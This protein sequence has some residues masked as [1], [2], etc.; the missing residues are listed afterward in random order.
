MTDVA[1]D[2]QAAG[3][4]EPESPRRPSVARPLA[5]LLLA[6]LLMT[7]IV[8][9][10]AVVVVTRA[11]GD[12]SVIG[13][14]LETAMPYLAAA[15]HLVLFGLLL[16]FLR[17]DGLGLKEIGWELPEGGSVKAASI[18]L[19]VGLAAGV[20]IYWI[21][22]GALE[23]LIHWLKAAAAVGDVRFRGASLRP[24]AAA[25]VTGTLI[26]GVVEESVWRGYAIRRF[27]RRWSAGAAVA[28][29]S[30]L[31]GLLHWG[32]GWEG[33]VITGINGALLAGLFLW[34]KSLLAPAIA[35]ATVNALVLI[36]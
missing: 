8:T 28:L 15:N 22:T 36:F 20:A 10:W 23:P 7:A 18:E 9:A 29:S 25:F 33:V 6:P 11:G 13:P 34:R 32:L 2:S 14:G 35:H 4:P 12:Q 31:F 19:A 21:Q 5:L 16:L 1:P 26:A 27:A 24:G 3:S 30:V 17:R